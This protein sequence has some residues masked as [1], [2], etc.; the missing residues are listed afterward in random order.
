[1]ALLMEHVNH[2][3]DGAR[4]LCC[5][6]VVLLNITSTWPKPGGYR[7]ANQAYPPHLIAN[8][9]LAVNVMQVELRNGFKEH[10]WFFS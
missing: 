10:L 2:A 7:Q 5:S 3:A 9:G 1:M 4:S 8:N 6:Q